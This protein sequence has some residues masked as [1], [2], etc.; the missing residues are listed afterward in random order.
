MDKERLA[1]G[2]CSSLC[3][4]VVPM[5]FVKTTMTALIFIL[6]DVTTTLS[7]ATAKIMIAV[8]RMLTVDSR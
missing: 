3:G 1:P 8:N 4:Q 2:C 5:D 7:R 6:L